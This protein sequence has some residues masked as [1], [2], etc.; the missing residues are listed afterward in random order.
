MRNGKYI[1][2][3]FFTFCGVLFSEETDKKPLIQFGLSGLERSRFLSWESKNEYEF[4][5]V[6]EAELGDAFLTVELIPYAADLGKEDDHDISEEVKYVAIS[7]NIKAP[8]EKP[9]IKIVYD[10]DLKKDSLINDSD[11]KFEFV[12][13]NSDGEMVS[14]LLFNDIFFVRAKNQK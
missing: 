1:W 11:T 13:L 8:A 5:G 6:Y 14:G 7:I 10:L 12:K 2:V 9:E 4:R 3:I